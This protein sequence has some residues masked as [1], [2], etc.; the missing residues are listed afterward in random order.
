MQLC[1]YTQD[2]GLTDWLQTGRLLL[3]P[4]QAVLRPAAVGWSVQATGST[5][6]RPRRT[7]V[8]VRSSSS[9]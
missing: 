4:P 3:A 6:D 5:M 1:T 8:L 7:Y 2:L 9:H